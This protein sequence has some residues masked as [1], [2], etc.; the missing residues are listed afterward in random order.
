MMGSNT[1]PYSTVRRCKAGMALVVLGYVLL[2]PSVCQAFMSG[3]LRE[4]EHTCCTTPEANK[5]SG[6]RPDIPDK[7]ESCPFREIDNLKLDK[8]ADPK[9]EFVP[10][11][12]DF[13]AV[14]VIWPQIA[15]DGRSVE[16]RAT[17]SGPPQFFV[18]LRILFSVFRI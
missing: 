4:S 17:G 8:P 16:A 11:P 14:D 7:A 6:R 2:G 10:K 12:A 3:S 9:V 13:V 18:P 15:I 5:T 1:I